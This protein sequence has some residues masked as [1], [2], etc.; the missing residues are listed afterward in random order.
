MI[1]SQ[2][3]ASADL[4]DSVRVPLSNATVLAK[5]RPSIPIAQGTAP[6]SACRSA[7]RAADLAFWLARPMAE[8]IAAVEA[9]RTQVAAAIE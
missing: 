9:L 8:R 5:A 7:Q 2:T 4:K 6:F 1:G 3:F